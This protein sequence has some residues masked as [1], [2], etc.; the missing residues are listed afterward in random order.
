MAE[1]VDSLTSKL[2]YRLQEL[3]ATGRFE[4]APLVDYL[5]S[6]MRMVVNDLEPLAKDSTLAFVASTRSMD[7]P[8]EFLR[9]KRATI[10]GVPLSLTDPDVL[11]QLAEADGKD[12]WE[13]DTGTP[14]DC[15]I[16]GLN[17]FL[18]PLP[19]ADVTVNLRH[20][21][22]P[23]DLTQGGAFPLP[24]VLAEG[25]LL[26]AL[27]TAL[28]SDDNPRAITELQK[29]TGWM[30]DMLRRQRARTTAPFTRVRMARR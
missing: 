4:T 5:T 22:M 1:T 19:D 12:T 7:L 11:D 6:G 29:Y 26:Y 30:T 3:S 10:A 13:E 25:V 23:D 24:T 28:D 2:R 8:V 17:L 16:D 15:W 21:Y 9:L 27:H 20:T 14:T 18:Y